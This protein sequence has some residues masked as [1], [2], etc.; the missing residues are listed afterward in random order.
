MNGFD[1]RSYTNKRIGFVINYS[2]IPA[3]HFVEYKERNAEISMVSIN[4][5]Y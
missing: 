3:I 1:N 5:F 4:D 2:Q